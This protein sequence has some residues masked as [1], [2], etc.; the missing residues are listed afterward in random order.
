[1]I[2]KR[3]PR[4]PAHG[5][6]QASTGSLRGSLH[7][8]SAQT[9]TRGA[10]DRH[11][12]TI[13]GLCGNAEAIPTKPRLPAPTRLP[14]PGSPGYPG[15]DQTTGLLGPRPWLQPRGGSSHL[16]QGLPLSDSNPKGSQETGP[17]SRT[18]GDS[19]GRPPGLCVGP[20]S[21]P[22]LP[23]HSPAGGVKAPP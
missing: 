2:W 1:M 3:G 12:V 20:D 7:Q 22:T 4:V 6:D 19:E 18:R 9:S 10:T 13:P 8:Q 14:G 16:E 17:T 23:N 5:L 15:T 11:H 21:A